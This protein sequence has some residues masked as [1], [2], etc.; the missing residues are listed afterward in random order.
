MHTV[1]DVPAFALEERAQVALRGES[2]L[3]KTTLLHLI[4]GILR[5]DGGSIRLAGRELTGLS[6]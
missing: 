2:G 6:E 1:I 4:A 3:G 5:A